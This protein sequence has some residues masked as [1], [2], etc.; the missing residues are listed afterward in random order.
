M[1]MRLSKILAQAIG[2]IVVLIAILAIAVS[3]LYAVRLCSNELLKD[4]R[5]VTSGSGQFRIEFRGPLESVYS[6]VF[7]RSERIGER[8]EISIYKRLIVGPFAKMGFLRTPVSTDSVFEAIPQKTENGI[9]AAPLGTFGFSSPTFVLR[10]DLGVT[11]LPLS[12]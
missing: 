8:V 3:Q 11:P 12:R 6:P 1:G 5:V 4:V 2:V 9:L 10:T 7:V